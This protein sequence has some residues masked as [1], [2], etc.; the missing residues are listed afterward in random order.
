MTRRPN[1]HVAPQ[2][3]NRRIFAALTTLLLIPWLQVA[4][5]QQQDQPRS[6]PEDDHATPSLAPTPLAG[7]RPSLETPHVY[8]RRKTT[9]AADVNNPIRN[10][11]RLNPHSRSDS[12]LAPDD[13]SADALALDLSVRAPPS[14]GL[15]TYPGGGGFSQQIA[16]SLED[17]E[18]EDIVLLATVDGDL[19]ASDRRT[20]EERWHYK[21]AQPMVETRHFRTHHSVLDEDYSEI[22]HYIWVVEPTRD[23]ELYLWRPSGGLVK[24]PWTMKMVV[25]DLS[26]LKENGLYYNG[27]KKTT[28]VT[29]NADTGTVIKEF[30]AS[31][32]FVNQVN[33]DSCLKPNTL[34]DGDSGE[35]INSGTIT[36]GRTDYMVSIHRLD[37]NPIAFLKYSE[38]GPNTQD[39]DLIQQNRITKDSHYITSL[40]D[41]QVYGFD[42]ARFG[43]E[44]PVF[45]KSLSS[46]VARV[47]DVLRPWG[48]SSGSN[49]DLIALP[50]P[51]LPTSDD[52]NLRLRSE[53]VFVNQT[54]AGSWYALSGS[55]YPFAVL[56]KPAGVPG[57]EW[58]GLQD[59][60]DTVN[61]A[62]LSKALVGIHRLPNRQ[63]AGIKGRSGHLLIDPP[64]ESGDVSH[65]ESTLPPPALPP[66]LE[67][68]LMLET[69]KR[70]PEL[71]AATIISLISNPA[72]IVLFFVILFFYKENIVRSCKSL[73]KKLWKAYEQR[74]TD[75]QAKD[76]PA[77]PNPELDPNEPA[78]AN[79]KDDAE[80]AGTP[81]PR[82]PEPQVSGPTPAAA[83]DPDS[84]ET[85]NPLIPPNA[86]IKDTPSPTVTFADPPELP[87]KP[88]S[89]SPDGAL[90][91]AKHKKKA[92]R[93]RRG[94][95]KHQKGGLGKDKREIS[96]SRDD[97]PPESTVDEVVNKAKQLGEVP[98]LE[99]DIITV[100]NGVEDVSGPILKMGSLEVNMAQQLGTGSNGTVVFA[101]KWD[102]RDVAIKRMLVQFNEIASQETKLLRESD[103]H[104]NVI[105]YFAQQEAASFLYIALELCQASLADIV[106]KPS[107][108][109]ELARAG[110]RDMQGVLYQVVNGLSHLHR[111]RIVHRDLKPQ[112]ILVNMHKDGRPR[113]LV[114]DFGLCKKLEGGQSSFGATT[115]HAAGTVG[116]RAP[117]LLVDDDGPGNTS[118]TLDPH[119]SLHSASGTSSAAAGENG[120][121]SN[122]RVTRAIDIFSLGLVFFYVL[123]KGSHPFDCG[124]RYMREVN[125][126]KGK[127]NL[128]HLDVLGD[129]A[130]EARDL[131]E[132][133]IQS[134]PKQRPTAVEVMAHPFFWSPK[135]RLSFLCDVSDFFEKEPRDPPSEALARLETEATEVINGDFLKQLP[136]EFV[137]SL[138]KQR[139][140]TGTRM[141]DLLRAL[142][143]KRYHYDD[144][145]ESLMKLVGPLPDGYLGFWTR[146][147]PSLLIRCWNVVYDLRWDET[148]RF[149]E[150]YEPALSVG[151]Y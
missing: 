143:N 97:D 75:S 63:S 146:K 138:G 28:M 4:D 70:L 73:D 99:P 57:P 84:D 40:S 144:M 66:R 55:R 125:I 25:E 26:P 43:V 23:G 98:K 103:D 14:L 36:L 71:V 44:R 18:V 136:K 42:Y 8:D 13:A 134:N 87:D 109:L 60:W 114:S 106:Q 110:E 142:R 137:D 12:I 123:T 46:P 47:F 29:L 22:D 79:G 101:G 62:A 89:E 148:D 39:N 45:T 116:W 53:K 48:T 141:L 108:F 92:H 147:F 33:S 111:L 77:P 6:P 129:I 19:Y 37:G 49:P 74:F 68:N 104:P 2:R 85:R 91:G 82:L 120:P 118:M 140:Y 21:A 32:T 59:S 107:Q 105:R 41:G 64:R 51:P 35:C 1:G 50:Q 149:R 102:G 135:K 52:D 15:S 131:I 121:A 132:S 61:E 38:W 93:G 124:D 27:D 20:G 65:S 16:R 56:A 67:P 72:A 90:D 130:Y 126:R 115:A 96:Q 58:W 113:L 54:E 83:T 100:G 30:S 76:I 127:Y 139:K 122:R 86:P 3:R 145:S 34:A 11:N 150:Y 151:L 80:L 94:G 95:K 117:E 31:G 69:L 5:A 81:D 17:W 9:F 119:S 133:M 78:T 128:D 7:H 24:M 10:R 88:R 112:N